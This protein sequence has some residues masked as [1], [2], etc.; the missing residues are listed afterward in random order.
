MRRCSSC[1]ESKKLSAFGRQKLYAVKASSKTH[2]F[3]SE[4]KE[5]RTSVEKVRYQ[6]MTEEQKLRAKSRELLR[7]YGITLEQYNE[8][9][10]NQNGCCAGCARHQ[11]EFDKSLAVDHSHKSGAFRSLLCAGCNLAIGNVTE[12][13]ETLLRLHALLLNYEHA[14]SI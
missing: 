1:G 13:P 12:N 9:F 8:Q 2:N 4:C 6:N 11:S 7:L 14:A 3:R 10:I 5:C